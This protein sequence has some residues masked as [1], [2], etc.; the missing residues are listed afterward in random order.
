MLPD[1][2]QLTEDVDDF[3]AQDGSFLRSRPAL[4]N[5]P[6]T[7]VEKLRTAGRTHQV[8]KPPSSA[9][10]GQEAGF[11]PSFGIRA[12]FGCPAAGDQVISSRKT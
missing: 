3:L 2:W 7:D 6:L 1:D 4:P 8:P 5:T 11:A 12:E 10:W 9:D